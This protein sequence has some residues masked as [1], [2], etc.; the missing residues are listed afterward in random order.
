MRAAWAQV[1][2]GNHRAG[3]HLGCDRSET[4]SERTCVLNTIRS[5]RWVHPIRIALK[6][7]TWSRAANVPL[8]QR[9][10][11]AGHV[12]RTTLG[13]LSGDR[14]PHRDRDLYVFL[15]AVLVRPQV[16]GVIVEAGAFKGV[17]TAKISH[18]AAMQS[19]RLLVFDSFGGL[20]DNTEQHEYSILGHSIEGWF[21]GGCLRRHDRGGASDRRTLRSLITRQLLPWVV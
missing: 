14:Q 5:Q 18:L 21:G 3:C 6:G 7:L 2:D 12:Y 17:S 20:P 4:M 19:R 8:H 1:R 15:D 11:L 13:N 16:P 9:I 10:L